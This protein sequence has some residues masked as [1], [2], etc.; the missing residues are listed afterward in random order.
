MSL[1]GYKVINMSIAL[2][3][4]MSSHVLRIAR[5]KVILYYV[6]VSRYGEC[7]LEKV[8]TFHIVNQSRKC[9][10]SNQIIVGLVHRNDGIRNFI[11]KCLPNL[12]SLPPLC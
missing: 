8:C 5:D 4:G 1:D 3:H 7:H 9:V 11:S 12:H 10:D 6:V 2:S